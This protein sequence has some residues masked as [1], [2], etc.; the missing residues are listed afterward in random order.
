MGIA[1]QSEKQIQ[2]SL[3][4][5]FDFAQGPVEMT[6][7]FAAAGWGDLPFLLLR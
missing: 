2:G 6:C 7:V 4:C 5:P 3:H 1:E